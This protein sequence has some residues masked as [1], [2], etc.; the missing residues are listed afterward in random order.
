M[1]VEDAGTGPPS[2]RST[3][4]AAGPTSSAGSP[5]PAVLSRPVGGSAG[6]PAGGTS[7]I[8][9]WVDD[10]DG[11]STNS[12][13]RPSS[14]SAI[15]WAR[16]WRC[17][18]A[19]RGRIASGLVFVGGLP[20]VRPPIRERLE[21]ASRRAG[22]APAISQGGASRS[23]PASSPPPRS[24]TRPELVAAFERLFEAQSLDA[25]VRCCVCSSTPT[26][27]HL[28]G[29]V[30]VPCVAVTGAD[31]QYAPPEPS[32]RSSQLPGTPRLEVIDACGHLPF[33][34]QPDAFAAVVKAFLRTC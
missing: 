12:M 6:H 5:P 29:S 22:Q 32:R 19:R 14:S 34:E 4:S 30:R 11:L 28:V 33:L 26:P 18:R 31:D 17:T 2:S 21:R 15:R 10:L 7:S 23:R 24:P 16:S 8:D 20:R 9:A 3:A 25:Y 13:P 1:Y 27:T